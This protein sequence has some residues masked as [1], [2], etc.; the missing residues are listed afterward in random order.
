[1]AYPK[2]I[3]LIFFAGFLMGGCGVAT[4]TTTL[5]DRGGN[6]DSPIREEASPPMMGVTS[7]STT[8][9]GLREAYREWKGT[10]YRWGGTTLGGIDCSMFVNTVFEDYFDIKLP[11]RTRAQL[12][13]GKGVRRS[14]IRTGDLVFFRT[15]RKTLHVG[16]MMNQKEFMHASTSE[17]VTI[18]RIAA[19][20]WS[21]RYLAAR[22]VM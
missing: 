13:A 8:E 3:L 4:R 21:N 17:G 14:V 16:I 6:E 1:M 22:R 18:S 20:Y 10:P 15:G 2:A 9:A 11:R 19:S 7:V 12:S 5:A